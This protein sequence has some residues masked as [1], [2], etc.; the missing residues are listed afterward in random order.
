MASIWEMIRKN[1]QNE[2]RKNLYSPPPPPPTTYAPGGYTPPPPPPPPIISDRADE[3]F[4]RFKPPPPPPIRKITP[5]EAE[6]VTEILEDTGIKPNFNLGPTT[7]NF[8][9]FP[10][11]PPAPPSNETPPA[12]EEPPEESEETQDPPVVED[13]PVVQPN[14]VS[15]KP[16]TPPPPPP[17][18]SPPPVKSAPIDTVLF[19]D[20]LISEEVIADLLFE[21]IGGQEILAISR[22]DTVNGEDVR[23]N[24]IQNINQIKQDYNPKNIINVRDNSER[25][26]NN[27]TIRLNNRLPKEGLG[28]DGNNAFFNNEGELVIELVN[29]L[30]DEKVEVQITESGGT[31]YEAGI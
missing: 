8:P 16:Q 14:F 31:I 23:Y 30:P 24:P 15:T 7:P 28:S 11:F 22:F 18:P 27:F 12:T 4:D 21:D 17:P 2:S 9:N 26:F 1:K 25:V 19:N 3:K 10:N 29:L 5:E 20:D 13:D 6:N